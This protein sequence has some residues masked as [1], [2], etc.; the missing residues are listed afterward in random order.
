MLINIECINASYSM[1]KGDKLIQRNIIY[2]QC[3]IDLYRYSIFTQRWTMYS[4]INSFMYSKIQ[5][6]LTKIIRDAKV[7][8]LTINS[9]MYSSYDNIYYMQIE[10]RNTGV[11]LHLKQYKL[12]YYASH[13]RQSNLHYNNSYKIYVVITDIIIYY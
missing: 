5:Q 8:T 13:Y 1:Q 9:T 4:R 12:L 3:R 10:T 11:L 7:M 2:I 6:I